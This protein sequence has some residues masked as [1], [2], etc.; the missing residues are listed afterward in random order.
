LKLFGFDS[1]NKMTEITQFRAEKISNKTCISKS[2]DCVSWMNEKKN[3]QAHK[4]FAQ[5]VFTVTPKHKNNF[6]FA[7][8]LL[9][10]EISSYKSIAHC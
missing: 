9:F 8:P 6:Q 10:W 5:I 2:N 4:L 3:R 7:N 1:V